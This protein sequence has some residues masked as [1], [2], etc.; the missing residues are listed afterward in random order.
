MKGIELALQVVH[1][2]LAATARSRPEWIRATRK[3]REL[4]LAAWS[5]ISAIKGLMTSAVP[6]VHGRNW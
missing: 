1:A 3:P 5:S 6:P 2:G 4:S